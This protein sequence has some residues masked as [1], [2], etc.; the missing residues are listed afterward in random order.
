MNGEFW[1]FALL[2]LAFISFIFFIFYIMFESD[3][4]RKKKHPNSSKYTDKKGNPKPLSVERDDKILRLKMLYAEKMIW[5]IKHFGVDYRNDYIT[6]DPKTDNYWLW[7]NVI[8]IG[9]SFKE[10]MI[11]NGERYLYPRTIPL[12]STEIGVTKCCNDD[13]A[14]KW[15]YQFMYDFINLIESYEGRLSEEEAAE[16]DELKIDYRNLLTM[17]DRFVHTKITLESIT[18]Y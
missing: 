17:P 9:K 6:I 16:F 18:E 7:K 3:E 2:V 5:A 14:P 8:T 1:V 15:V 10:G 13:D 11:A 4:D 12:V